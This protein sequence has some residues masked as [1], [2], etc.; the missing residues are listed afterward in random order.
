[1]RFAAAADTASFMAAVETV[2]EPVDGLSVV[3]P[4]PPDATLVDL[5]LT[6]A[7]TLVV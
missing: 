4:A 2:L 1:M 6:L 7:G 5:G 3:A